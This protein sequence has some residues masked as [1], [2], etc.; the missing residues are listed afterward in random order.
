MNDLTGSMHDLISLGT[1]LVGIT[2][3]MDRIGKLDTW[4]KIH[5]WEGLDRARDI[6]KMYM[7]HSRSSSWTPCSE[8]EALPKTSDTC[9][10]INHGIIDIG[11]YDG[12]FWHFRD[13]NEFEKNE[14]MES[15]K[16]VQAWMPLPEPYK[17]V[18]R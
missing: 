18:M 6:L 16:D 4:Q 1:V 2:E 12:H 8:G 11:Y 15:G 17:E 5:Y 9:L 13:G 14:L 7:F 10:I 3:A